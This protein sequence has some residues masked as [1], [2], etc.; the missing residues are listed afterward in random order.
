MVMKSFVIRLWAASILFGCV[1]LSASSAC[2]VAQTAP[3]AKPDSQ[4][5]TQS[6]LDKAR[7]LEGRGRMDLAVQTW[8][9]I[10]LKDPKNT[11]ALGGLAR[12][13][14][15]SGNVALSQTYLER[16]RRIDP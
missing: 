8:K 7:A 1:L 14:A 11:E 5:V 3:A 6:L 9:Q 16:L 10:L 13:A 12:A 4:S 15:L 2:L